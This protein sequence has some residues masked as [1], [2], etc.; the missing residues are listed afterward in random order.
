MNTFLIVLRC[1]NSDIPISIY[2]NLSEA[3]GAA[4]QLA[5]NVRDNYTIVH[6]YARLVNDHHRDPICVSIYQFVS[7][8]LRMIVGNYYISDGR[9]IRVPM[10]NRPRLGIVSE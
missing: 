5:Q 6:T 4:T 3:V 10:N 8:E 1:S 9:A 7:N 2:D